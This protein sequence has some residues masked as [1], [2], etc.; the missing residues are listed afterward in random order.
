MNILGLSFDYHDSAAALLC[1]GT[2]VAAGQEERFSRRKHDATFPDRALAFCLERAGLRARDL[3]AVV[4]YENTLEKLDRVVESFCETGDGY[5]EY[6][7]YVA[8]S[9]VAGRKFDPLNH[10]A[11]RHGIPRDRIHA[12]S[13][14]VSHASSA[15]FCSPFAEAAVIT[16]DGVGEYETTTVSVGRG[17]HIEKLCA[18]RLPDS[19]GL[20]YSAFTAFL[21]FE[22]NEGEYK[23]M[24]MAGFGKPIH[25]DALRAIIDL[26]PDGLFRLDQSWFSFRCP[27]DLPYTPRMVERFGPPRQHE[28]EFRC[29]TGGRPPAD[30]VEESC[31][32]YADIAA[33]L[34]LVT[35]EAILHI[36][37]SAM[38]RTGLDTVCIAGGVGL[39][40]LA[41]ARVQRELG[42]RLFVQPAAG[43][44]GS[45]LG[46]ALHH[47]CVTLGLP[48]PPPLVVPYL[49]A[50]H[51]DDAI[52]AE[53]DR[54]NLRTR[55]IPD[56]E[57]LIRATVDLLE[58]GAVV[59]WM[60]G[61]GEWGPRALGNRSILANPTRAD[62]QTIVNVK[63]KFREPFRPFAPSVVAERA[64]EFFE[65][66]EPHSPSS[67]EHFMLAVGRVRPG[68]R[69]RV[70][71]VAHVD[72]TARVHLVRRDTA[73]LFYDLITAFGE[74][75]GVPVLLNTSFNLKGEAMVDRPWDALET[76]AWSEMDAL[77]MGHHLLIREEFA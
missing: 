68:Q 35:E 49:G 60:Q 61:R 74:R 51:S 25:A 8:E 37:A 16:M 30:A 10:I 21:G 72:G 48:R 45:A 67:P 75:T 33:S 5:P 53:C 39:N 77:V 38:K 29:A 69:A 22:V 31:G 4:F 26:T 71:A 70:P 57:A 27:R 44:A 12:V 40:S 9:W 55:H 2:I 64:A 19:L 28:S 52:K 63:I 36:V 17:N 14:H 7:D 15:F 58:A 13:H 42:C 24:G 6:L 18:T 59:G 73:P 3:D 20:F 34:Q 41:N 54:H 46:A 56:R 43:D 1:D 76:F 11:D 47:H 65:F 62:M 23:V 66:A 50:E 32:R